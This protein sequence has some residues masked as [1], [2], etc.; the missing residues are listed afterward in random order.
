MKGTA[1]TRLCVSRVKKRLSCLL[2][3]GAVALWTPPVASAQHESLCDNSFEDCRAPIISLIRNETVGLDVSFWFMT[4]TRYSAE[5]IKRWQAGVPVRVLLDLRADAN[6]PSNA[7]VRQSLINAGI[8]I[9]H[10]TTTGINHWKMILYAGQNTVHFTAANFSN[11]SYSPVTPYTKYVDEVIYFTSDPA[12]VQ[13]FMTKYDD[14]WT[15]TSHYANLANINGPLVRTYGTYPRDSQL[16]FPPDEDYQDRLVAQMRGETQQIDVLMFRITSGKA[17][18]ELLRRRQAGVPIRIITDKDQYRNE[19]YFWHAYNIDRLYA[20]GI[21]IKWRRDDAMSDEDM[22]QKS[23]VLYSKNLAVFGS[24]N[25]TASSSDSQRE[26]NYFTT[27]EWFVQWF[28]NQFERK[29][30][31]MRAD[32]APMSPEMYLDFS[33]GWPETPVNT[34]PAN[35]ALG[36]GTSVP[37][38][39]EGGYWAHKYDVYFGTTNPP[40]LIAEDFMPGS[41]TA[42]I[43]SNKET[44]NPCAPPAPFVSVC[45][46]GLTPGTTYYWKVRGK[47]MVGNSR[48][49]TGP[50]WSFTT[51]GGMPPPPEPTA[52]VATPVSSTR[53]DLAWTDVEGE[54][55]YKV[56]R[57]LASTTTWAQIGTTAA[58]VT[59]YQD[60][61][62]LT[63]STQYNYRVRAW[64]TGG[65]SGYSNTAT[66]STAAVSPSSGRIVNDAY[67]RAGQY[68]T[69]NYGRATELVAKFSADTQYHRQALI[70]L[71][72]SAIDPFITTS[73]VLRI[74]GKLSDTRAPSVQTDIYAGTDV[75][76]NETTV[77]W[78]TKPAAPTHTGASVVVSGT[79]SQWYDIDLTAFLL[80]QRALGVTSL[81]LALIPPAD[82]LPYVSFGSRES[83]LRPELIITP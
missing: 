28:K 4:D 14:L 79:T 8:P 75:S 52:L 24:S 47:T 29:W 82:T 56:E 10:K 6:Y 41:A 11:G 35:A 53:I 49:I 23:V 63:P 30:N 68:A 15:N 72:I 78:N 9:R 71:D 66:A 45:P 21:P 83:T 42:G 46:E 48:A 17:P 13:T 64:T 31:N 20:A 25:W 62:G 18:D 34:S 65:N 50:T 69:T 39:W 58:G 81:T 33:P 2:L 77:T 36:L 3:L 40:P 55:G 16:N 27:K 37:L 54:D 44:F 38:K 51:A 80:Q 76:W 1:V 26:H 43:S 73:V 7:N 67:V 57:K 5:I 59:T 32:G 22:H 60:S 70:K 19:T 61:N 12:V 74:A